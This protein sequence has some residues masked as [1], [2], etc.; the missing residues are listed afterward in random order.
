MRTLTKVI[1]VRAATLLLLI[2][3]FL[4]PAETIASIPTLIQ[5]QG[6]LMSPDRQPVTGEVLLVARVYDHPT[7]GSV[8]W[9]EAH[10]ATVS[11]GRFTVQLGSVDP[12]GNP[13][14][15]GLF[16][17][18]DRWLGIRIGGDTE[19]IPRHR[20]PS[21]P[22]TTSAGLSHSAVEGSITGPMISDHTLTP[23]KLSGCATGEVLVMSTAGWVCGPDPFPIEK[24]G[25]GK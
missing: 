22:F 8:L 23:D 1:G 10:T 21:V 18:P 17:E 25:G 20:F 6:L 7:Q 15:G 12:E 19:M 13:L 4:V 24:R 14:V 5:F 16:A 9:E 2:L 3:T 11:N